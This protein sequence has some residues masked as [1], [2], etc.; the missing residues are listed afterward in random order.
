[1]YCIN[2]KFSVICND[3]RTKY[4]RALLLLTVKWNQQFPL[5]SRLHGFKPGFYKYFSCSIA[6]L[7]EGD[8]GISF[9][10]L[11]RNKI[12]LAM[13]THGESGGKA[14]LILKLCSNWRGVRL[15]APAALPLG[16]NSVA[17]GVGGLTATL[18]VRKTRKISDLCRESNSVTIFNK[19]P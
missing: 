9:S 17:R 16:E 6:W 19:L 7:L 13:K 4:F 2:I 11:F 10:L 14:P 15:E 3:T 5:Y 8:C 12:V 1:V 18:G